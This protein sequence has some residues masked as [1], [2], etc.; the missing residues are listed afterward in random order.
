MTTS[1][2]A[3]VPVA[4]SHS[5]LWP[6]PLT[7]YQLDGGF[8]GGYQRLNRE[9][10]IPHCDASL[11]R[12]GWI[13]NFRAAVQGSLATDRVGRLFTDS[14]IYKTLEGMA[15]ET[16]RQSS[17]ELTSRL[18]ELTAL[19]AAAQADDGYLNTYFGYPGGPDR[20]SDMELG[21]E[22][23]CAGHLLQAAV[24]VLR[25]GG[26]AELV[27]VARRAADH[28]CERFGVDGVP[29]LCGHPEIETALV[30]FYR[31]TGEQRYLDQAKIFVDRRGHQTLD[32]TM[33]GGRDYYQDNVPVRDA[34]VLVGHAVRALYL[35]AG[36]V[37]VAVETGDDELLNRL[38]AQYDRTLERRTYL[39]GGMGSHHAGETY[40]EDFELPSERA[41]AET[42][43]AVAS[44]QLAWR[45]LL[46]TGDEHYADVIE[47]TLYN[48]VIASPS[49]DGRSFFYVNTLQRRSPGIEPEV[50]GP[51]LR[52]TDGRRA[53]W[54]TTSCCPTNLA[55]LFASLSGYL[56]TTDDSGVQLHQYATGTLHVTFAENRRATLQVETDYPADGTVRVRVTETD[57]Q[58]WALTLRVPE[59]ATAATLTD[60][61]D[62]REVQPGTTTISRTWAV[63]DEVVLAI[64]MNP[65]YVY[66]DPRVDA[67]RGS[68]AVERGPLVYCAE[69]V[70]QPD[71]DLD[72]VAVDVA[73]G[74]S[75]R[76]S[77]Q[78]PAGGAV[79]TT[80]VGVVEVPRQPWSFGSGAPTVVGRR[81]LSLIP[82]HS[83]ANRE[84]S[85]M[86]VWLPRADVAA[87]PAA[88]MG[89]T[90]QEQAVRS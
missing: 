18:A 85:T 61:Q 74:L 64:D 78:A 79:L 63:G 52:R 58:P 33:H 75:D 72:L 31:A 49:T 3:P 20:Y 35:A 71:L 21:H 41:Y 2:S 47:R 17:D 54:F 42:C 4:P 60:G 5:R 38:R 16:A 28:I 86:R 39:T 68:V 34:E 14:E 80:E 13:G 8:W 44:V 11:E 65:R 10:V 76:T 48:T 62:E 15:W 23:Y 32:D 6:V 1:P 26:P 82:Y 9:A 7:D 22:L 73:A 24:A 36:A 40:G 90:D 53:S 77:G 66:P 89:R 69:S 12:V 43:A 25:C 51:S 70:D 27:E 45:L 55:R 46:A 50:G 19:I 87:L 29:T 83:W 57:D 84:P 59:W 37:D 67:L 56:A 88:A 81:S 30:E